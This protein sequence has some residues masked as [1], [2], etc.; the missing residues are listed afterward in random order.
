MANYRAVSGG[1]W[2]ALARWQDDSTG[3][4]VASTV[5]P[6]A[7]DVVYSNNFTVTLDID[8]TVLE[9]RNTSALNVNPGGGFDFGAAASVVANIYAQQSTCLSNPTTGVKTVVGNGFAGNVNSPIAV[10]N[11]SSGTINMTGN[12]LGGTAGNQ[13]WGG[14]NASSGTFNLTGNA[15]ANSGPTAFGIVNDSTGTTNVIGDVT[16]GLGTNSRG[17]QNSSTG[18]LVVTRAI[19][20]ALNAG[21]FGSNVAGTTVVQHVV[22]DA[23]GRQGAEGF[24]KFSNAGPNTLAGPR[25]NGTTQTLVDASVGNPAVTDVRSGVTYAS[26]ALTGTCAVP[27][28]ASVGFGVPVDNTTGTALF[29]PQD[30]FTAIANSSDPI[31]ERLRNVSTVATTAATVAAFDV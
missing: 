27:P 24:V 25:Q 15:T 17:A 14:A 19:A 22:N 23:N 28:A 21:I 26:G 2:S 10:R 3:S 13:P 7:T 11:A 4:Y 18:T 5:L 8:V 30:L 31:A 12:L 9:L 20:S 16:A 1:V 29:S 6:G